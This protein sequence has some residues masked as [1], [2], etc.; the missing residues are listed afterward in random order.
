MRR[1][2]MR[3]FVMLEIERYLSAD[4]TRWV[5]VNGKPGD[6]LYLHPSHIIECADSGPMYRTPQKEDRVLDR[7]SDGKWDITGKQVI[8]WTQWKSSHPFLCFPAPERE[9]YEE[10][11]EE[12][13]NHV[14]DRYNALIKAGKITPVQGEEDREKIEVKTEF[15]EQRGPKTIKKKPD[16]APEREEINCLTCRQKMNKQYYPCRPCIDSGMSGNK[17][18]AYWQPKDEPDPAEWCGGALGG[19]L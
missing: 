16:P 13:I 19:V 5:P 3:R 7:Y 14:W 2:V 17:K 15:I 9:E 6:D 11:S 4:L 18:Y 1:F 8:A 12:E 10:W